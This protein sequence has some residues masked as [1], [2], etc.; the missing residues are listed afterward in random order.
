MG[1]SR[2]FSFTTTLLGLIWQNF[3][4]FQFLRTV[5]HEFGHISG[6]GHEQNGENLESLR[7]YDISYEQSFSKKLV[8]GGFELDSDEMKIGP[9]LPFSNMSYLNSQ[10][11]TEAAERTRLICSL[12]SLNFFDGPVFYPLLN[13]QKVFDPYFNRTNGFTLDLDFIRE[14]LCPDPTYQEFNPKYQFEH[15]QLLDHVTQSA[16]RSLYLHTPLD[17]FNADDY[18]KINYLQRVW[19]PIRNSGWFKPE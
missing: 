19:I 6:M 9:M 11:L 12:K 10:Y 4:F 7:R 2:N 13:I 14:K 15:Q 8:K 16:I 3:G 1:R 17:Q 18:R 5:V